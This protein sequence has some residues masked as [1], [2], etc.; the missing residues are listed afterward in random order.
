MISGRTAEEAT[1]RARHA[2]TTYFE[3]AADELPKPE[4]SGEA[5]HFMD[6]RV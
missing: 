2:L 4:R 1:S 6:V 3:A 5:V